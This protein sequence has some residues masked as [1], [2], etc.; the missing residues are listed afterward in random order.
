MK[1]TALI[2]TALT[3][4]AGAAYAAMVPISQSAHNLNNGSATGEICIYCHTPH[5]AVVPIPLWNRTNPSPGDFNANLYK[6]SPTLSQAAKDSVLTTESISL[7]CM[8]CHDGN[9]AMEAVVNANVAG[10]ISPR[11]TGALA[12]NNAKNL[13]T[14]LTNDHPIGF[15]YKLAQEE[16]SGLR[17]DDLVLNDY[18]KAADAAEGRTTSQNFLYGAGTNGGNLFECSSCHRVHDAGPSGNF[19]RMENGQS[20]LCLACHIK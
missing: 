19:L 18:F 15:D 9:T 11:I 10:S 7:F 3:L 20:K 1:K 16:D 14:D 6:T 8:S 17:R 2:V 4:T 13:K 5:N 12:A